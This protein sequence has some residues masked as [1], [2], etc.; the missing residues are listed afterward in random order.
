MH[1]RWVL[2]LEHIL[3]L[4]VCLSYDAIK[5]DF[6]LLFFIQVWSIFLCW[7]VQKQLNHVAVAYLY[8]Q[9][10]FLF[11]QIYL[12]LVSSCMFVENHKLSS[13]QFQ[14]RHYSCVILS[15]QWFTLTPNCT[16]WFV[17]IL[18]V[19]VAT[20][21]AVLWLFHFDVCIDCLFIRDICHRLLS[22]FIPCILDH[23]LCMIPQISLI[24]YFFFFPKNKFIF[25]FG[26]IWGLKIVWFL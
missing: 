2:P 22:I 18:L 1:N 10:R 11:I 7:L 17:L 5:S 19:N 23:S 24:Q 14:I 8:V 20:F 25:I 13:C 4:I 12:N 6:P 3:S 26:F 15:S 16:N 21:L 9:Q